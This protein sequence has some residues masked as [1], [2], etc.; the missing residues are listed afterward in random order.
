MGFRFRGIIV[1]E[2]YLRNDFYRTFINACMCVVY[3][4]N[5]ILCAKIFQS[6]EGQEKAVA[7]TLSANH[8]KNRIKPAEIMPGHWSG[9]LV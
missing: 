5:M 9:C 3:T 7:Y 6:I 1:R 2:H 4:I 8:K